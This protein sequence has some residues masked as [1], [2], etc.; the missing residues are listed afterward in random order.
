[1][2]ETVSGTPVLEKQSRFLA[3]GTPFSS[4]DDP[5]ELTGLLS[6]QYR[7][8][9]ASHLSWAVRLSN[10]TEVKNDGGESGSGRCILDVMREM[11][12]ENCLVLVARWYGG[13]HLGGLRFRIYRR[14]TAE[15][16][17]SFSSPL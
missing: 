15:L 9:K 7:L 11:D 8:K 14:T 4:G 3:C 17:S 6:K 10:G 13:K 2:K 5:K 1:M 16:I 12:V